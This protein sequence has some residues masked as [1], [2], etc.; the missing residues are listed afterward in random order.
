MFPVLFIEDERV[1]LAPPNKALKK[2]M[3]HLREHLSRMAQL[4]TDRI[5]PSW[6]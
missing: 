1:G 3:A 5:P 2:E 6:G 4:S